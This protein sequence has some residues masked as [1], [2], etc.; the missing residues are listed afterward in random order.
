MYTYVIEL[1]G[2]LNELILVKLKTSIKYI[3]SS[4]VIV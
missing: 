3:L 2:K 4:K 1:L